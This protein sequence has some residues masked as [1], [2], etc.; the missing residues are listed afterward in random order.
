MAVF[1]KV[2]PRRQ[3]DMLARGS[4]YVERSFLGQRSFVMLKD[5]TWDLNGEGRPRRKRQNSAP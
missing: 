1:S 4:D 5:L 2:A 3:Y